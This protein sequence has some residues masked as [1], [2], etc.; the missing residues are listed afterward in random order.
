MCIRV[1][2]FSKRKCCKQF[3]SLN[4]IVFLVKDRYDIVL[5]KGFAVLTSNPQTRSKTINAA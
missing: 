2:S 4:P 3:I 1:N 5:Q